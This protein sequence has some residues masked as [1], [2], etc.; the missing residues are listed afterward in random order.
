MTELF[1][2]GTDIENPERFSKHIINEK[3]VSIL[4]K[5][6]FTAKEISHNLNS[7]KPYLCFAI[8]FSFKEAFYKALNNKQSEFDWKEIEILDDN[9][10]P[11]K[12]RIR[13][14]GKLKNIFEDMSIDIDN[15]LQINKE[16]IITRIIL[17]IRKGMPE[18]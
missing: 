1:G 5:D 11:D 2:I 3:N 4:L 14:L 7:E 16:Y 15:S 13:L 18:T 9:I 10:I 6:I 8:G 17:W 12:Y